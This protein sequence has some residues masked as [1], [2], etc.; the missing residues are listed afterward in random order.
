MLR[1]YET[2]RRRSLGAKKSS[3]KKEPGK[4]R[5]ITKGMIYEP[6]VR[7]WNHI[8]PTLDFQNSDSGPKIGALRNQVIRPLYDVRMHNFEAVYAKYKLELCKNKAK[9]GV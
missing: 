8:K 6:S 7:L 2:R 1:I 9:F 4:R 3:S 5:K